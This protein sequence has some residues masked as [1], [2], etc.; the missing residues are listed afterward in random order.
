MSYYLMYGGSRRTR[1]LEPEVRELTAVQ[2]PFFLCWHH[3]ELF[4]VLLESDIVFRISLLRL[5]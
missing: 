1:T 2:N 3:L 4:A 5:G